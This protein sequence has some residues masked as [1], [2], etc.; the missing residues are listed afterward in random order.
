MFKRLTALHLCIC[1]L[2]LGLLG[3]IAYL[4]VDN[5]YS[6]SGRNNSI[7]LDIDLKRGTFYDKNMD[8]F[9]Y[10]K[11]EY[12]A[13]L[14]PNEKVITSLNKIFS[15]AE[16]ESIIKRLQSGKPILQRVPDGT[17]STSE[18]PVI[19]VWKRYNTPQILSHLIGLASTEAENR[20]GLE[21]SFYDFL[22]TDA[23]LKIKYHVDAKGRMLEGDS[24]EIISNHYNSQRG[25]QL[26]ID[27]KLQQICEQAADETDSFERGSIVVLDVTTSEIRAMVSRPNINLNQ[28]SDN[29]NDS[30]SP[31]INRSLTAYTVGSVFKLAVAAAAIE[32]GLQDFTHTCN[33]SIQIGNTVFNCHKLEGHGPMN[34]KSAIA[35]SC[36]P[37]FIDLGQQ[38]GG[39]IL[40]NKVT[41]FGFGE[42]TYLADGLYGTA[43]TL[44]TMRA[45]QEAGTL[46]NFSFGQGDL[47]ATP[48]QV[49][50]M[51][52]CIANNGCYQTPS[53]IKNL[54]DD[55]GEIIKNE[56][57]EKSKNNIMK[58]ST[59]KM[60]QNYMV[61]TVENGSGKNA[62]PLDGGAGGKT[63]TAQSGWIKENGEEV[64]HVWFAGF[65]PADTPEYAIVVMNEDGKSGAVQC[66]PIFK[67]IADQIKAQ[68]LT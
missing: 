48:L 50:N 11:K 17:N 47:M 5:T 14:R 57:T 62:R 1:I 26:T 52:A 55:N 42:E 24:G 38:I 68:N 37:F 16:I 54:I 30:N 2:F 6:V 29:M 9:L 28:L 35:Q 36:N 58:E 32:N 40:L 15:D 19:T 43:G 34:L 59:A 63:A 10:Q 20:F 12:I 67:Q 7:S 18:I 66:G 45:V 4:G 65:Y 21:K 23:S 13:I 61:E 41:D 22:T 39:T 49:A 3:R 8:S 44:P 56:S 64:L 53:L 60:I 27:K 46:A 33:G 25:I 51:V 31:F